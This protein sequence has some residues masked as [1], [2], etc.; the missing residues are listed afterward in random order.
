MSWSQWAE[1]EAEQLHRAL[2]WR[3]THAFDARGTRG[4]Y[5]GRE[6]TTQSSTVA[7]LHATR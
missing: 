2:R 3:T 6:V 7:P 5:R 4:S 1:R